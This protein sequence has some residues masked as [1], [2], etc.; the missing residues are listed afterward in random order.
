MFKRQTS[1]SV[2]C[3]SCGYLVGV[4]DETCYH[5]GRRNPGLWGFA[6]ALRSLGNDLGFVPFMTGFCIV[7]YAVTLLATGGLMTGGGLG[8]LLAPSQ[9]A[10]VAFG[11]SGFVPVFGLHRWWTVLSAG[12]LHGSLVHIVLNLWGLRILAPIVSELYGPG[13]LVVIYTVATILGFLLSSVAGY[14]L[15]FLPVNLHFGAPVTIGASAAIFGLIGAVLY[16]GHRTGSRHVSSQAW[17][18]AVPNIILGLLFPGIDNAA[19]IGGFLGGYLASMGLDPLKPERVKHMF[20]AVCCLALSVA[21]IA[22]SFLTRPDL[23]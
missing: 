11:A 4:N 9:Y 3:A 19:H 23:R 22:A 18:W 1:G 20:W 13:R 14:L 21:S 5:C 7:M 2:V 17:Q 15:V 16:Y 10:L 6:P 8:G 12:F